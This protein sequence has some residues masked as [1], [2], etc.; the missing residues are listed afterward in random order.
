M[1]RK[2]LIN[3][4]GGPSIGKT[5]AAAELFMELKKNHVEVE[6]VSEF[7][8]DVV[9][10]GRVD[11]LKHQ[12]YI[13]GTQAY[14]IDTSYKCMQVTITDSPILLGPIYDADSSPALLALSLEHH[15]KYN[16]VNLVL[17]RNPEF[18]HSM[19]GRVHSL[20]ESVSIDNRIIRFLEDNNIP[21]LM[22]DE[23][24]KERIVGLV[25]RQLKP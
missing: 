16:N 23:Y 6:L 3:I 7:A 22:Y 1:S 17:T 5:T 20:T 10:E 12:W 25:L 8:K 19:A 11:A 21:Y 4:F 14:R 24:G 2:L 18:E 9:V 15:A 13:T